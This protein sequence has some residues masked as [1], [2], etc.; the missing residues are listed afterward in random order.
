MAGAQFERLVAWAKQDHGA[1]KVERPDT[2]ESHNWI[3]KL[4]VRD[5][6]I[7]SAFGRGRTVDDAAGQVIDQLRTVGVDVP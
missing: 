5:P 3:V 4:L 2:R 6:V 1:I 7:F